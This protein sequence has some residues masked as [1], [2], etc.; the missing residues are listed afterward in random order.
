MNDFDIEASMK[1]INGWLNYLNGNFPGEGWDPEQS[2]PVLKL[3]SPS[4]PA[5]TSSGRD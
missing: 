5:A 1:Q 4:S 2:R 3:L